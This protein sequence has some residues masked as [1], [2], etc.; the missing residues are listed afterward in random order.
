MTLEGHRLLPPERRA[1]ILPESRFKHR[2]ELCAGSKHIELESEERR[3]FAQCGVERA[4]P[5]WHWPLLDMVLQLPAYWHFRDGRHKVLLRQAMRER[6]P[7]RVVNSGRVGLLGDFFLRGIE[8]QRQ[9]LLETVFRHPRSDWQRYVT[10]DWLEPYLSA[11][12]SIEFGHTIL[13]RVIS[14]ELWHRRLMGRR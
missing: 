2:Y 4:N 1:P 9:D 13:W 3:L 11:T 8:I 10:R 6:L 7:D 12:R 14:Y 5:F